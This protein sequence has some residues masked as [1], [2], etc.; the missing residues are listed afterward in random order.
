MFEIYHTSK[1]CLSYASVIEGLIAQHFTKSSIIDFSNVHSVSRSDAL[2]PTSLISPF[3]VYE[4]TQERFSIIKRLAGFPITTYLLDDTALNSGKGSESILNY[5]HPQS[6]I[7]LPWSHR[8]GALSRKFPSHNISYLPLPIHLD[9]EHN[10]TANTV[11]IGFTGSLE[12]RLEETYLDLRKVYPSEEVKVVNLNTNE[13]L[14]RTTLGFENLGLD[15][16]IFPESIEHLFKE[17][18]DCKLVVYPHNSSLR[19]IHWSYLYCL[20]YNIPSVLGLISDLESI[21]IGAPRY[22]LG[23]QS[24]TSEFGSDLSIPEVSPLNRSFS[25]YIEEVHSKAT[26]LYEFRRIVVG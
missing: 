21:P 26:F 15:I 6:K 17:L 24:F 19:D 5:I 16:G 23:S 12:S 2:I 18:G 25:G 22:Y 9:V 13:S 11:L 14:L 8:V 7:L 10:S 1:S 4:D 20:K 3:I